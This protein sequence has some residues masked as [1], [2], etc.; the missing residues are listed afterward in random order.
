MPGERHA[1][2]VGQ[3]QP[4]NGSDVKALLERR[5]PRLLHRLRMLKHA[6]IGLWEPELALLPL[7]VDPG[8]AAVDVGA[9]IGIYASVL[10]AHCRVC[11]AVEP[12]PHLADYLERVLP[13]NCV[14]H[15]AA[16]SD[17]AGTASLGVPVFGRRR[18]FG[19]A[20]LEGRGAAAAEADDWIRHL[21][22]T[23]RLDDLIAE[24]V[25]FM[26]I[27][28]E[29]HELAVLAGAAETIAT[30][31]PALLVEIERRHNANSF[32][33]VVA[34]LR[35]WS[36]KAYFYTKGRLVAAER[37]DVAQH[38]NPAEVGRGEYVNNFLFLP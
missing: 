29:G 36:Y 11:H 20:T 31:R 9:N 17:R 34:T 37:F 18:R 30:W 22:P 12:L 1:L 28:V 16:L 25:G 35:G 21:V 14:V 10:A 4:L 5:L 38:Q 13:A 27:D 19:W 33:Q 15:R 6:R 23:R 24:P 2:T 32:E 8:S 26:K 7:F 3:A